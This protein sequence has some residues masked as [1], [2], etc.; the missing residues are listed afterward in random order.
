MPISLKELSPG[1]KSVVV[2]ID[3]RGAVRKRL[4]DMGITP[5]TEIQVLRTAPLG[6]PLEISLRGY[7]LSLRKAE[8]Q[9]VIMDDLDFSEGEAV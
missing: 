2:R 5:G 8:A 6:D 9:A 1:Q 7:K 4:L 3:G